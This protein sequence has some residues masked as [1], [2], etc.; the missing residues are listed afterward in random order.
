[1]NGQ[2]TEPAAQGDQEK[3]ISQILIYRKFQRDGPGNANEKKIK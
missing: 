3:L 2:N 1:M